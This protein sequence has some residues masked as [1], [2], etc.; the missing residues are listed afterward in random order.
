VQCS[1]GIFVSCRQAVFS[2]YELCSDKNQLTIAKYD[3]DTSINTGCIACNLRFRTPSID[4]MMEGDSF[5]YCS[6]I[7]VAQGAAGAAAR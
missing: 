3:E 5:I 1:A 6:T 4:L 2:S 7:D